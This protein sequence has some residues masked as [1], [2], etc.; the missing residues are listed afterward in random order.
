MPRLVAALDADIL[1]P[2]ILSRDF[3]LTAFDLVLYEPVVS[4]KAIVEMN[5]TLSQTSHFE[6]LN[7]Q[8][9]S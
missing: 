4:T 5:G 7:P 8:A 2:I 9:H 3:L 6:P 1:V